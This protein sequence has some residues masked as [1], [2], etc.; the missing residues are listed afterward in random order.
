V[1]AGVGKPHGGGQRGLAAHVGRWI[2]REENK[3]QKDQKGPKVACIALARSTGSRLLIGS[4]PAVDALPRR[5]G[6]IFRRFR[7]AC[8]SLRCPLPGLP[9]AWPPP[10][11]LGSCRHE[12]CSGPRR[13][14]Q[15]PAVNWWRRAWSARQGG[16][17]SPTW[18]STQ[19][20]LSNH[21]PAC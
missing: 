7:S 15:R 21:R 20:H 17:R 3:A 10:H 5:Q 14:P 11:P 13:G 18:L 6:T 9:L 4:V 12:T 16:P 2:A 19:R 8:R 1:R